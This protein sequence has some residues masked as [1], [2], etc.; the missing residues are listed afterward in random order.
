MRYE[1]LLDS[2][3]IKSKRNT[4]FRRYS[5]SEMISESYKSIYEC[6]RGT[7]LHKIAEAHLKDVR[8]NPT[9]IERLSRQ[10][11]NLKYVSSLVESG[12]VKD[13]ELLV[14][15]EKYTP[16]EPKEEEIKESDS[17]ET[18]EEVVVEEEDC[19]EDESTESEEV[20]LT[21]E[22]VEE[23]TKHLAELRKNKKCSESKSETEEE[24]EIKETTKPRRLKRAVTES[25]NTRTYESLDLTEFNKKSA[26]KAFMKTFKKMQEKLKEGTAL[27][28]QESISLYKAANSAMTHLSVELEHNPDFLATF[29]ESVSLLSSDVD[30]LLSSLKEGKAPSKSNMKSLAKFTEALLKESRSIEEMIMDAYNHF[31]SDLGRIPSVDDVL[32]D[33]VD[34]YTL[35]GYSDDTPQETSKLYD[36]VEST[37]RKNKVEF[38]VDESDEELPPIEDEEGETISTEEPQEVDEFDQEYADARVE[39]HKEIAEEHADDENPEVQEKIA[40]DAE[41]VANL[42]GVTDEQ[43]EELLGEESEESSETEEESVEEEPTEETEESLDVEVDEEDDSDITDDELDALKQHLKEMRRAKRMKESEDIVAQVTKALD[44]AGISYEVNGNKNDRVIVSKE[45]LK[46]ASEIS[47]EIDKDRKVMV[48]SRA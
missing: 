12:K 16:V 26:S 34:N 37:L 41:E 36:K 6:E 43:R 25:S 11:S 33:L 28:R 18:E 7:N 24:V 10:L 27:T 8:E 46:K 1:K 3:S 39:L 32:K 15:E 23:L 31:T 22:E 35:E 2:L 48:G 5:L 21:E 9:D 14:P 20:D 45:D 13:Q 38:E 42:P 29:K 4:S 17:V 30:R 47:Q 40:Q 19:R 44:D